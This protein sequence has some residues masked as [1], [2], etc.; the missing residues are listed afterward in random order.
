MDEGCWISICYVYVYFMYCLPLQSG[1]EL[2]RGF[3]SSQG[4][5]LDRD[6]ESSLDNNSFYED[7]NLSSYMYDDLSSP[8]I[9]EAT[10]HLEEVNHETDTAWYTISSDGSFLSLPRVTE[11]EEGIYSCQVANEAGVAHK[12]FRL[13][14]LG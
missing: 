12:T 3:R 1:Q 11:Q 4:A 9:R 2:E 13:D 14:V 7:S 10:T 8:F 5:Q 6:R